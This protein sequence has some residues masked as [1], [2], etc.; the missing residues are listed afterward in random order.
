[1]RIIFKKCRLFLEYFL[2][3]ILFLVLSILPLNIVSGFGGYL[4]KLIGPLS[5]AHKTARSNYKKIFKSLNNYEINLDIS[6]SWENL[7]RTMFELSVLNRIVDKKNNKIFLT[8]LENLKQINEKNEQ[9]IFFSIHQSNW[10]ILVPIIDS[11][12]FSVGA[13]YRHLNN[14][15]IDHL[16]LKKRNQNIDTKKSFYSAKGKESAKQILSAIKNRSSM[17]LLVDQKDT[18]GELIKF[19]D[20][21]TKTQTGF[22]KIA[23][24]Y[25]LKLIPVKNTRFKK[26]NFKINFYPP[27]KPFEKNISEGKAMLSIHKIVEKW[28]KDNPT[29]WLWQ[30]NR[31]N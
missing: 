5:K 8:G 12:G 10:E 7:G 17:I 24:K 22:L 3:K 11:L 1:M 25:N 31:F 15:F 16:I 18:A 21:D 28:I 30:H 13:I 29:Q 2:I 19:F 20:I 27:I 4:F 23:K 14:K 6:K 26:N 9:V